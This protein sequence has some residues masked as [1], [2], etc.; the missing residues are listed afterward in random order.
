MIE[1]EGLEEV[2][3]KPRG[4]GMKFAAIAFVAFLIGGAAGFAGSG[5]DPFGAEAATPGD[6]DSTDEGAEELYED[7][8]K[9]VPLE[10]FTVNLRG[11]GGGRV[12]RLEVQLEINGSDSE[13]VAKATPRLRDAVLSLA[14]DYT[15][16]EIEGIDGKMHFRD[17][18]L[19][20]LNRMLEGPRIQRIYFTEF[21]VH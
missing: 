6:S 17:E 7:D 9:I 21:V 8:R 19:G 14:S 16:T 18:L 4:N 12:L 20:R 3:Y 13:R 2:D 15:Y 11:S 1:D 10:P 5:M